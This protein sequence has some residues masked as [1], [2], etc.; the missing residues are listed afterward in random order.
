MRGHDEPLPWGSLSLLAWT[1]QTIPC[2]VYA[3]SIICL[4][5]KKKCAVQKLAQSF[6]H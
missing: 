3:K 6:L 5:K 2:M 4:K 1:P